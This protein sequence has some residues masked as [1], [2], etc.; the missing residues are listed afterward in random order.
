MIASRIVAVVV[1]LFCVPGCVT[2]E[3]YPAGTL[4]DTVAG[5]TYDLYIPAN[6]A[7]RNLLLLP[8]W[9]FPRTGWIENTSIRRYA[10]AE[11]IALIM[12]E[13]DR[14]L[15]ESS[16]YP[17]TTLKWHPELPG[18]KFIHDL[19]LPAIRSRHHLLLDSQK[20]FLLGLSTGGRGV[21][22]I[23][24]ENPDLFRAGAALSGDF[25]QEAMPRDRLMRAVYGP[26]QKFRERWTTRDNPMGRADEWKMALYLAH[27]TADRIVPPSQTKAFCNRL[28]GIPSLKGRIVCHMANGAGHDYRFW[29]GELDAVFRFFR[30]YY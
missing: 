17:E 6:Y 20:N 19:F 16:Y 23:A 25:A 26:I 4:T 15:Y 28:K 3:H 2:A 11:G 9:K 24:L 13:M 29:G 12:P 10:D 30:P 7:K 1:T 18:G 21:A 22:L 5:V 8:G 27:G 14:T